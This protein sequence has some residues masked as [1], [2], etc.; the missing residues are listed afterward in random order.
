MVNYVTIILIVVTLRNSILAKRT[1]ISS[2]GFVYKVP[3]YL[4]Q[5]VLTS[6]I[7]TLSTSSASQRHPGDRDRS[8]LLDQ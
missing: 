1:L 3:Y 2:E 4:V 8:Q 5:T 6:T 7:H